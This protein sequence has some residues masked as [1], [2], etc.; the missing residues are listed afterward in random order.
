MKALVYDIHAFE[1]PLFESQ[2][3]RYGHALSFLPARLTEQTASL[4]QGYDA[5]V[6]FANDRVNAPTLDTL[7]AS[8]VRFLALRCAGFNHVDVAHAKKLGISVARVPRYSPY[9]VAEHAVAMLLSLNRKIHKAYARVRDAN[10]SL[11]GLVGFDVHGKTVGIVGTGKIGESFARILGGFGAKLL[12]Y[13][14]SPNR[15]LEK[16]IGLEYVGRVEDLYRESRVISLHAPLTPSTRHMID[17]R[18]IEC[19]KAGVFLINTGRGALIDTPALIRGLKSGKIGAAALDVYEEEEGVFFSD[20]SQDILQDDVL[21]R[22][23]T[24]PNVLITSH[25]AFLTQ[26]ALENIVVTTLENLRAFEKG[27]SLLNRVEA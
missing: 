10:F 3:E 8:G 2:N 17:A 5:V 21:A 14:P 19:M 20:H 24:F 27:E 18:A 7:Y 9:A 4:A 1:R 26:E 12:A 15:A 11:D 6:S 16:E 13:D 22:L 23:L 25:Q